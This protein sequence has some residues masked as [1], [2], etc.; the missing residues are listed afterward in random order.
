MLLECSGL[1]KKLWTEAGGTGYNAESGAG[2]DI[3]TARTERKRQNDLDEDGG[4][5]GEGMG[6]EYFI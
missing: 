6:R 2:E 5:T 1:K 3:R 4:R